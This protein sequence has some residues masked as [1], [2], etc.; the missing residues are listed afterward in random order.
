MVNNRN[1]TNMF[2]GELFATVAILEA[3]KEIALVFEH[4]PRKSFS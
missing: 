1:G 4:M 2:L 3:A